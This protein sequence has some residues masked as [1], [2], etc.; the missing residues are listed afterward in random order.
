MSEKAQAQSEGMKLS[1]G[2]RINPDEE[3]TSDSLDNNDTR[4]NQAGD[5]GSHAAASGSSDEG[6][7]TLAKTG[8]ETKLFAG[9]A[10]AIAGSF[11][12]TLMWFSRKQERQS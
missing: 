6:T 4:L 3:T 7:Q 11:G 12:A 9:I 2:K 10:A 1:T 8:S 5:D